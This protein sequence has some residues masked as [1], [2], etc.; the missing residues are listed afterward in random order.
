[1]NIKNL[2]YPLSL[3][4]AAMTLT[5]CSST[6]SEEAVTAETAKAGQTG[7]FQVSINVGPAQTRAISVG[8]NNCHTLYTNWDDGDKVRVVQGTTKLE[9]LTA[10][11]SAGN[12]A[13]ATLT[14]TLTGT[15]NV[16]DELT[17]YYHDAD[18]DYTGQT[19]TIGCVSTSKSF[20][21]ATSTVQQINQGTGTISNNGGYLVMSNASYSP[22]QAYLDISF[23]DDDSKALAITQ[24]DIWTSGGKLV[25]TAPL[26]GEKTYATEESPLTVTPDAATDHFFLALRDEAGASNTIY[27][28]A[29]T[30]NNAYTYSQESNL[31]IGGYYYAASPKAMTSLRGTITRGD[32]GTVPEPSNNCYYFYQNGSNPI[33]V[34]LSGML[35]G[36][37]FS[38]NDA[39]TVHLIDL[40][41]EYSGFSETLHSSRDL[42]LDI[43]GD[44]SVIHK[45]AQNSVDCYGN[46]YLRG[47]GTLTVSGT[48]SSYCGLWG[49]NNYSNGGDPSVLA[50]DGYTVTR[51]DAT[52]FGTYYTW[53]YTVKPA[54]P[55]SGKFTINANGGQVSFSKGNLQATTRDNGAHWSWDF[56]TNQWDCIGNAAA[57]N[58]IN[59]NGTVS[60]NGTVDLFGWVGASSGFTGGAQY[61]ISNS[62]TVSDYGTSASESLKSDWG[63]TIG[64]GWRTL[65]S[66]EWVYLLATRTS[67]STVNGTSN[68]RCTMATINTDGT[69]VKGLI[70]FPDGVTIAADEATSWGDI[71]NHSNYATNC[72]TDQWTA[73]AAK[74]CVFL[75]A[76]GSRWG[77]VIN[78]VGN[79]GL[80]WSSTPYKYSADD[81]HYLSFYSTLLSPNNYSKRNGGCAVRLVKDVQ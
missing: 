22:M 53:T 26:G 45:T 4:M 52:A 41:A 29:T 6:E 11:V 60:T 31:A 17:L 1:M 30:A 37:R 32:G 67:G 24:L 34:T 48:N 2:F 59:G 49:Q 18:L 8:G 54:G 79:N 68:A 66:D 58:A 13:Y 78:D 42:T 27:F 15:F 73:L 55:L 74:G 40:Q 38:F 28:K 25:K 23:T 10:D 77:Y 63:N 44:N 3:A 20:L 19:G 64:T 33:D 9:Q 7:T 76:A 12:T 61:G 75:P 14:G 36:Y 39:C 69:A 16:G 62:T 57:N 43:A 72:T 35:K 46:L 21:T 56:A 70:L 80:Y 5:A 51:S 71:N 65:T 47:N 81:A 50:A